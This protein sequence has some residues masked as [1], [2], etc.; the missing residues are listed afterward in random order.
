MLAVI[1][2]FCTPAVAADNADA[3]EGKEDAAY[4][5]AI[6]DALAEYDARHFEEARIL[7][8]RAHEIDPNARTLRG[9][10]MA[11]F[12]LRDYVAAVHALS[13]ALIETRKP[14]TLEQR[15][16]AEGL[17]ERSR[18]FI[19]TY[20]L[21]MTPPDARLLID[22]RAPESEADGTLL[23]GFGTHTVEATRDGYVLRSFPISVRGGERKDLV[24][25]LE[26]KPSTTVTRAPAERVG[27]GP[28]SD[29]PASG[30]P[31]VLPSGGHGLGAS[32]TW[33]LAAGTA[34]LMGV[35]AGAYWLFESD[36]LSSC[37]NPPDGQRCNNTGAIET[38][39]NLG[40]AGTAV[41]GAAAVTMAVIGMLSGSRATDSHS[42][43]GVSCTLTPSALLCAAPF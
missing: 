15:A 11:S 34:G 36:Q 4:R 21:K 37:R 27:P 39:R 33:L 29:G 19:D 20:T 25:T 5:A 42:S 41:A 22:G 12:E 6:R 38:K 3:A 18:L 43:S 35:G 30:P 32:T 16:H 1:V 9:I 40:I 24:I 31:K 14:L 28:R 8:R 23:L 13:T 2:C 26:R 17:L 7:F 10:G